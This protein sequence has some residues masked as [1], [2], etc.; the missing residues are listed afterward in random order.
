V[1]RLLVLFWRVS[2][3]DLRFLWAALRHPARPGWLLP[4]T[5]VLGLYALSPFNFAIP[6]LGAV[7][8]FVVVPLILHWLV[9][10]LPAHL[11]EPTVSPRTRPL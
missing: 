6:L 3:H 1:K 10:L 7:D 5:I 11:G 4:V 2:R 8:D 9:K